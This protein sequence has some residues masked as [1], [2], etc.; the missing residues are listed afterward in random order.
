MMEAALKFLITEADINAAIRR[1]LNSQDDL[2]VL[3]TLKFVFD[4]YDRFTV[5]NTPRSE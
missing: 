5:S 3:E 2:T 4:H 1:L